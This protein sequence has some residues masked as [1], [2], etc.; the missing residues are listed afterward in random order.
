MRENGSKVRWKTHGSLWLFFAVLPLILQTSSE[1][2]WH[3]LHLFARFGLVLVRSV[4]G[5]LIPPFFHFF[6]PRLLS[7]RSLLHP[8][9][10]CPFLASFLLDWWW[11]VA[12]PLGN[13]FSSIPAANSD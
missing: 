13:D 5:L 6:S 3:L 2:H 11:F 10:S 4:V 1:W 8:A 12:V 9:A 7:S